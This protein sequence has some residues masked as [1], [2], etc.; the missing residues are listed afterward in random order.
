[1]VNVFSNKKGFTILEALIA[2]V[3]FSL[4]LIFM[5]QSF[6]LAY[7]LNYIKLVKDETIK[8]AQEQLELLRNESYS[9][10]VT[11][12]AGTCN[13]FDPA[14]SPPECTINRQIRNNTV[15][16]G[17]EISVSEDEPYKSVTLTICTNKKDRFGNPIKYT[18][19]TIISN[20]GF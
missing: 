1:M 13:N 2:M 3:I 20:K 19:T 11:S 12:C 10:I 7:Q 4:V 15:V 5:A 6:L 9:N 14:A 16:F 8:I 17:K 18:V